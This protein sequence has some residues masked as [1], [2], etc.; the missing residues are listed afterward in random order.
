MKNI[1]IG[2][3]DDH[4]II[5]DGF[6]TILELQDGYHV[7]GTASNGREAIDLAKKTPDIML[8]DIQMPLMNGI[9]ATR[10]IKKS[11]PEICIIMLTSYTHG[12]DVIE[13]IAQGASGFLL[14]DWE[15]EEIIRAIREALANKSIQIPSSAADS[16]TDLVNKGHVSSTK[17]LY[18][19]T[20]DGLDI[21]LSEREKEIAYLIAE[22]YT[23]EQIAEELYLTLGTVKNYITSLYKKLNVSTR[24][25]AIKILK[26][27]IASIPTNE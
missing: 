3:V 14:K 23:N 16:I 18:D 19:T 26:N 21:H 9:E 24:S 12:N 11:H 8:M 15:T 27:A 1:A 7:I 13:A 5:V 4:P 25:E 10:R 17:D 20:W 2:I 6:K 22:R